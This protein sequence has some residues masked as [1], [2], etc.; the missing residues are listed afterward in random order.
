MVCFCLKKIDFKG[1]SVQFSYLAFFP[2]IAFSHV[3]IFLH[4]PIPLRLFRNSKDSILFCM[5]RRRRYGDSKRAPG[6][7]PGPVAFLFRRV[8]VFACSPWVCVWLLL[9]LPRKNMRVRRMGNTKLPVAGC[10]FECEG[11]W[12]FLCSLAMNC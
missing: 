5:F 8:C 1:Y 11:L 2:S 4:H 12:V 9:W 3:I 10:E 6:L 7:I